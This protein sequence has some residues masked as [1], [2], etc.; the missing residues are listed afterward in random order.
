M[1]SGVIDSLLHGKNVCI[2]RAERSGFYI[3]RE[4]PLADTSVSVGGTELPRRTGCH[5]PAA[6]TE[7]G[8]I[9]TLSPTSFPFD[10]PL[11]RSGPSM[12]DTEQ[13]RLLGETQRR[14]SGVSYGALTGR[15]LGNRLRPEPD[16]VYAFR[17]PL[18]RPLCTFQFGTPSGDTR[19]VHLRRAPVLRNPCHL[20][21]PP[22]PAPSPLG[23]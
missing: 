17:T 12:S 18:L 1:V 6:L 16:Q 20:C 10:E 22:C 19:S 8:N 5:C 23:V 7:H 13:A 9:A 11:S 4:A 2:I 15:T 3:L 14:D 21:P